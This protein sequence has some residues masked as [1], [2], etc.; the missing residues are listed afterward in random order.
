MAETEDL[1]DLNRFPTREKGLPERTV[2][3][4]SISPK[5]KRALKTRGYNA[6]ALLSLP[7]GDVTSERAYL[8]AKAQA[9]EEGTIYI[10]KESFE[11]LRLLFKSVGL[12]DEARG[13]EEDEV[14]QNKTEDVHT[15]LAELADFAPNRH[16]LDQSV[17]GQMEGPKGPVEKIPEKPSDSKPK[18]VKRKRKV[19]AQ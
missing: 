15:L 16:K 13:Q 9:I 7:R 11:A 6:V 4:E 10:S 2:Y 19:K 17:L 8:R 1:L 18:S 3:F 12:L 14:L 5:V